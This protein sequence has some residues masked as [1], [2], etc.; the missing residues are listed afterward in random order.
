MT[1]QASV[2]IV[3][4]LGYGPGSDERSWNPARLA[5]TRAL[6]R[7]EQKRLKFLNSRIRKYIREEAP[8]GFNRNG[9]LK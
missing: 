9:V 3:E 2:W 7:L 8:I 4:A 6:A 5:P 1:K